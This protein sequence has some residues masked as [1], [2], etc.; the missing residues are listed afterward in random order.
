MKAAAL[1]ALVSM[2]A[3]LGFSGVE[4]DREAVERAVAD[5]LEALYD[6][7]PEL[8]ERSVHK[9]LTKVGF[10]RRGEAKDYSGPYRMTFDQLHELA[11]EWNADGS[12]VNEDSP[13]KIEI[14]DVLDHTASAKLTAQWGID[15]FQLAKYD[16][17]WK[18]INV[19]W[20]SH[21]PVV[22]GGYAK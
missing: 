14:L 5:Y 12:K 1:L 2:F 18:I 13:R 20:Q 11:G 7:K 15:Y 10:A 19:L 22:E 8:I 4:E 9:D 16:G 17:K 6:V 21:P 3:F